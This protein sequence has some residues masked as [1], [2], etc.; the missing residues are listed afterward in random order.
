MDYNIGWLKLHRKLLTWGWYSD[1]NVRVTFIH[2]LLCANYEEKEWNGVKIP[3]GSFVSSTKHMSEKIG[4]SEMKLR[5]AL[6]KLNLTNEVTS[7]ST[8]KNTMYTIVCFDTY[9]EDNK[10]NNKP[11]TNEQQT[12][13][14]PITT[15]KEGKKLIS[16][17]VKKKED[18]NILT[19]G[20]LK[21]Y[22]GVCNQLPKVKDFS[23]SR[24][25]MIIA[26]AK[27]HGKD[28]VKEVLDNVST[29][30]FLNGINNKGWNADFN[31]I[32]N[33]QNFIKILEGN[34]KNKSNGKNR[35]KIDINEFESGIEAEFNRE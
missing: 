5:T 31:F 30:D 10:P 11:I 2:C 24:K 13:N 21:Y 3:R 12:D 35:R 15:T 19:D 27:E 17:E 18:T 32:F 23:T 1:L 20:V 7:K 8:T 25:K 22:H 33:K 6:K 29:S 28:K 4:I 14:K 34:Y 16:K 26:R 9:Q